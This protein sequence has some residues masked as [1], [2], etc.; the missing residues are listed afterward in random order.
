[1]IEL[2]YYALLCVVFLFAYGVAV[3]SLLYPRAE[4]NSWDLLYRIFYHP[5]L[6]MFADFESHLEVL[7]GMQLQ[8][9]D[10]L[11]FSLICLH[12]VYTI[13]QD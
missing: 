2:L 8:A 4:D 11:T 6:S 9:V 10:V 12:G 7:E 3:Q 5:Y 13:T 1:V